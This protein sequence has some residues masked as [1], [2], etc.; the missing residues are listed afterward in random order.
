MK[1]KFKKVVGLSMLLVCGTLLYAAPGPPSPKPPPPP[2]LP[3]NDYIGVLVLLSI[4]YGIYLI[5]HKLKT[6]TPR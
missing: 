6:K 4:L 2:K 3:I 5:N 1:D